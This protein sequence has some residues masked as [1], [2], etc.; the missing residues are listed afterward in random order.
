MN[1]LLIHGKRPLIGDVQL[2]G[3]QQTIMAIQAASILATQGT[4]IVDHVPATTHILHMN[5]LLQS[6]KVVLDFNRHTQVLKMDATRHVESVPISGEY[7][8]AAGP[9]LAR[10]RQVRLVDNGINPIYIQNIHRLTH[11]LAQLGATVSDNGE[12]VDIQA[13]YLEGTQLDLSDSSLSVTLTVMLVSTMAQNITVLHHPVDHPAVTELAKVLNRMGA[14]VHGAGTDTIRIQGVTFLHSTD[15]RALDDQEEAGMYLVLGAL[16]AGDV[17]VH[18]A[19]QRHLQ[20]L[21]HHL[22]HMGNT[23][24]VQRHGIRII[25]TALQLPIDISRQLYLNSGNYLKMGLLALAMQ[26][27]GDVRVD[28][29]PLTQWNLLGSVSNQ[30]FDDFNYHHERLTIHSPIQSF[31]D[32]ISVTSSIGGILAISCALTSEQLIKISPAEVASG[33]FRHFIDQL[34]SLG[35]QIDLKFN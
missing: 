35:A 9:I 15:Y 19:L 13:D 6:L 1:Q 20:P 21:L 4:V 12:I 29:V 23:V 7:L 5:Q 32:V 25:G 30:L 34:I 14:R 8:V 22:D 3:D 31:K 33:S 17:L 27:H 28:G 18:G 11:Y 10:C 24:I 2:S 16:T 26:A